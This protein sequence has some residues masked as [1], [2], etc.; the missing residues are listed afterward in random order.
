MIQ[1]GKR[2]RSEN[3]RAERNII[4]KKI[5]M[6]AAAAAA[7]STLAACGTK[8]TETV[9]NN[10]DKIQ[11]YTSFYAM[12][13][14]A[15][16][17][18]GDMADVHNLCPVGS[19]PHDFEPTASDMAALTEADLFIYN[20]MGMEH[21]TDSVNETL[22]G[23]DVIIVEAS[24]NVENIAENYDPHVWLDPENALAE[25][26][27]IADGF[28]Q[29]DP[30]NSDYY[31]ARLDDCRGRI[32]QLDNDYK[33]AVAGFTS[34]NIITSH[35]A[36]FNLCNAYGLI[37]L[38]VNGV[39]NSEDPTPTRMAEIIEFIKAND[40]KYVFTEPLSTS[41]IV[42][43]IADDT[44][45]ELLTLDPFEGSTEDKGYFDVMYENLEA[46][47]TALQ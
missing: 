16:E 23:S 39:D 36:Y 8:P 1:P 40:I 35:E 4:M 44:G 7:I 17:I 47:K 19:E 18:G 30:E 13:D 9:E 45:C 10:N 41:K 34:H 43:T 28:I 15:R 29:A 33:T 11:V 42:Q 38:A 14:F 46:L 32:E 25:M 37:Q 2:S 22:S 31:T 21:W 3:Q 27:A 6:T 5:L 20:G 26:E 24:A 12:Y